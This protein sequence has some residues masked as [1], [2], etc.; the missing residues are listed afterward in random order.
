[1]KYIFELSKEHSTLPKA[2]VIACLQAENIPYNIVET[3]ED[4][5]IIETSAK[6][7][8][9]KQLANR[10]SFTFHVNEFLFSCKPSPETIKQN[11]MDNPIRTKGSIAVRYKNRSNETGSKSVV[12]ALAEIYTKDRQVT[13]IK[14][15]NEIRALL[16]DNDVYVGLNITEID[17]TQFEQRKVQHRPFFSPISLHPKLAR[18]LVN[19]SGIRKDGILLDPF[20]GTGGFLIEAGLIGAKVIGSDIE[21]KM[22]DGGKKTL[23][24]Y[25]IKESDLFCSDIGDINNHVSEVDAV[26]TDLPYGK[27]TT[28]KGEDIRGLYERAFRNIAD[29]L[30]KH[31]KAVIGLSNKDMIDLGKSY[32]SLIEVHEWRAHRSLIRYFAVYQK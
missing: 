17:R 11:A 18:A 28:T 13:L 22:I 21:R 16:T 4:I 1:M 19:L 8:K 12:K 14:P 5:L 23:E 20:C 3:N 9:L 26:V 32:F 15:D 25:K 27:S 10:L 30:K 2:E 7:E 6:A 31:G 24:F 29:V